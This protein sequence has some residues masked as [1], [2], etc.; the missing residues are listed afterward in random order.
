ME[1]D[2]SHSIQTMEGVTEVRW[3]SLFSCMTSVSSNEPTLIMV[4][5]INQY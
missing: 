3:F 5:V 1:F 4:V 2:F